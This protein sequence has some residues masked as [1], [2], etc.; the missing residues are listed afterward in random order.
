MKKNKLIE[1][2]RQEIKKVLSEGVFDEFEEKEYDL[3]FGFSANS[4]DAVI[5]KFKKSKMNDEGWNEIK[6]IA[7]WLDDGFTFANMDEGF[8]WL[9]NMHDTQNVKPG[10]ASALEYSPNRWILAAKSPTGKTKSK[11]YNYEIM[12]ADKFTNES[13]GRV[14]KEDLRK[15]VKEEIKKVLK[16]IGSPI[17]PADKFTSEPRGR[18]RKEVVD[19]FIE[20]MG[21]ALKNRE[22]TINGQMD[23]FTDLN[24]VEFDKVQGMVNRNGWKL[25]TFDDNYQTKS[26][27]LI[28]LKGGIKEFI[29]S[30]N[31][32]D[33]LTNAAQDINKDI[34]NNRGQ[35]N[36]SN[37]QLI[38]RDKMDDILKDLDKRTEVK[39][40]L[41]GFTAKE[42][43]AKQFY[44][45][46][47][48]NVAISF[49][50]YRMSRG[51][52][53]QFLSFDGEYPKQEGMF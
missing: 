20:V 8:E 39:K 6:D 46:P 31:K 53:I 2:I 37:Y 32:L 50:K 21:K 18:V 43:E 35:Y 36:A 23:K 24:P 10:Y 38:V 13:R 26:Y 51:S 30:N 1:I 34:F 16:E 12:P 41:K 14:R 3:S 52:I 47:D 49:E 27:S 25:T 22:T 42:D 29:T 11:W 48:Y 40:Q 15:I 9:N 28:K 5:N 45:L 17:M 4:R 19:K 33:V 7:E 44:Q